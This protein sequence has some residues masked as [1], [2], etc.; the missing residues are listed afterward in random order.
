MSAAAEAKGAD[1]VTGLILAGG[2]GSRLGGQD[3]GLV[4]WQGRPLISHALERL[5]PQVDQLLISANRNRDA[6]AAFG[7][8]VLADAV[9]GFAGPLAGILAGLHA[10]RTPWLAV[11]P[12]DAPRLP[13]DLVARLLAEAITHNAPAAVAATVG[14]H[15]PTFCLCRR[16]LAPDL[17]AWLARDEHKLGAWLAHIGAIPV[18][19]DADGFANLNE[20]GDFARLI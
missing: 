15:Q 20:P 12:C 17:A 13:V 11:V 1:G 18:D 2:Q 10:S 9:A 5:A 14:R 3:K 16:Q 19:F 6:Y 8:P 4:A 7:W